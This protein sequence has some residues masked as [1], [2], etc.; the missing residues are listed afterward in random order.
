LKDYVSIKGGNGGVHIK[1]GV[2]NRA[3]LLA[4]RAIGGIPGKGQARSGIVTATQMPPDVDFARL[5]RETISAGKDL[6]P[7][8][9]SIAAKA[10]KASAAVACAKASR[11]HPMSS[12][13]S[14][15]SQDYRHSDACG[16]E[17]EK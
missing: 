1:V 7:G 16:V 12:R 13:S 9:L 8:D 6:F 14:Q 4:S 15:D 3:S 10:G 5:A 11:H 17:R 2:P